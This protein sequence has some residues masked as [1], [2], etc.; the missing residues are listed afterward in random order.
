MA[1]GALLP[2]LA[3]STSL[4]L[5]ACATGATDEFLTEGRVL[6]RVTAANAAPRRATR[7]RLVSTTVQ[8]SPRE[9]AAERAA[10]YRDD[11]DCS[12]AVRQ[13]EGA[14]L[15]TLAWELIVA[16]ARTGK[17]RNLQHMFDPPY[18]ARL[19]ERPRPEALDLVARVIAT[20]GGTFEADLPIVQRAGLP[21]TSLGDAVAR[22]LPAGSWI[23][24]RANVD[25]ERRVRGKRV[26]E[27]VE[28]GRRTQDRKAYAWGW[29]RAGEVY[30]S[31]IAKVGSSDVFDE[32]G[33]I[34]EAKLPDTL[35]FLGS[36]QFIFAGRFKGVRTEED[37]TYALVDV[38]E[39]YTPGTVTF[40]VAR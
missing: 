10:T 24:F 31:G 25:Q 27:L 5:G 40:D 38:V 26:A 4:A 33:R 22:L 7:P 13:A 3:L 16:C 15:R 14:D 37:A 12:R 20:R 36:G 19:A 2:P 21:L 30:V 34:V 1:L 17:W 35:P 23:I 11:I 28:M 18:G 29:D 9:E 39:V 6:A 8:K 32:T